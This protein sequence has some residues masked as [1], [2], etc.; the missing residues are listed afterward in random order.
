MTYFLKSAI[1]FKRILYCDFHF[2]LYLFQLSHA[3]RTRPISIKLFSNYANNDNMYVIYKS[4]KKQSL[5]RPLS[6]HHIVCN[7]WFYLQHNRKDRSNVSKMHRLWS[8]Y[9]VHTNHLKVAPSRCVSSRRSDVDRNFRCLLE[10]FV[11]VVHQVW[12]K[13]VARTK[14]VWT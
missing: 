3:N 1:H 12:L 11:L 7:I 6:L 13:S 8:A 10:C 4:I 14:S 5:L 9:V 2:C